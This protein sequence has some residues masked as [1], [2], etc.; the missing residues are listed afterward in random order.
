VSVTR[1]WCGCLGVTDYAMGGGGCGSG[2]VVF[3]SVKMSL[4]AVGRG[5][6]GGR[7]ILELLLVAYGKVLGGGQ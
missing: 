6:C 7:K 5:C 3:S 4:C 1:V 2:G